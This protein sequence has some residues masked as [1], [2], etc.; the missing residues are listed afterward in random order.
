MSSSTATLSSSSTTPLK[1]S[2]VSELIR[3]LSQ[4]L[5]APAR[6]NPDEWANEKRRLPLGSA[7]GGRYSAERTPYTKALQRA[8]VDPRFTHVIGV[9]ASQTSKTTST[10]NVIGERIDD[11]PVPVLYIGPTKSNVIGVIE[12]KLDEMLRLTPS[13]WSKTITGK[14]YTKVRKMIAGVTLRLA[15]AG[16][17]TELASDWAGLVIVDEIDRIEDDIKREGN[18][19]ELA[20]AR[21]ATYADGKTIVTSSPGEGNVETY[22]HPDTGLWHWRR[23]DPENV[24]SAIWLLWQ[25]GTAH[26]WAWPCPDCFEYFIPRF[27][28]LDFPSEKELDRSV[29]V[30]EV[31]SKARVVC[32]NCGSA[33]E[34]RQ[35][36][37]MNAR[38]VYVM[39]GQKPLRYQ[40]GDPC[41]YLADFTGSE[42]P[43]L[44]RGG[45]GVTP[46]EFHLFEL[47]EAAAGA[48][49][50]SLWSSGIATFATKKTFGFMAADYVKA[51]RSGK[52]SRIKGAITTGFGECFAFSGDAPQWQEVLGKAGNYV[53]EE[54]HESAEVLILTVDVQKRHLVYVLRA[55]NTKT[56]ES[57]LY[58]YGN[59]YGESHDT[60]KP[61][62][63]NEAGE[64]VTADYGSVPLG[65]V[66][67]DSGYRKDEVYAFCYK[68][69]GMAWPTKGN[70]NPGKPFWASPQDVDWRGRLIKNGIDLYN[71]DEDLFK[72]WVHT[73]VH[74]DPSDPGDWHLPKNISEDYCRQIVGEQRL[75]LPSGATVWKKVGAN[76][77]LDC[78][79]QQPL[80]F[81]ILKKRGWRLPV[82]E[83]ARP[84]PRRGDPGITTRDL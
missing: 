30:H 19:V 49:D 44:K 67:V 55:W 20:D 82:K 71:F 33:I 31:R 36:H 59:I 18:I 68:H 60:S 79:K 53:T 54:M 26:E 78:E 5:R 45:R 41:V 11:A 38:G 13:L 61:D 48:T 70:P 43:V 24:R 42:P 77:Y 56:E 74:W 16:S 37:W 15:W 34:S 22:K 84:A 73:R 76:D 1:N 50:F 4:I 81:R 63:W 80:A 3:D 62:V 28:L 21:H 10:F 32:P 69:R 27:E 83:S 75:T 14:R 9:L 46:V 47:T 2:G 25:D 52:E 40:N 7:E 51:K 65:I 8:A 39:P 64:F 72:S 17:P 23:A 57:W 58:D 66:L 35:K 29:P 6:R 12:P